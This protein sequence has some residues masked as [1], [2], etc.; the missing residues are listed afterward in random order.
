M[1]DPN[2]PDDPNTPDDIDGP[3]D[4][5]FDGADYDDK[6]DRQRLRGQ[7]LR[8]YALMKDGQW[9]TLSEISRQVMAPE[10]SVSANLRSF[11]KEKFGGYEVD[12]EYV[13]SGLY[14]Y[15]LIV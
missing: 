12:R 10:A 2:D 5:E 6:R 4:A 9:R 15:R 3:K 11:R 13:E 1:K 7:M 14:K 8:I